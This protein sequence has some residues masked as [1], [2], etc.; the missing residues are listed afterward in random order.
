MCG[1][2]A[3]LFK[4]VVRVVVCESVCV[5]VSLYLCVYVSVYVVVCVSVHTCVGDAQVIHPSALCELKSEAHGAQC[6]HHA[7]DAAALVPFLPQRP[8]LHLVIVRIPAHSGCQ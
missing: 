1:G 8:P 6:V 3:C 7:L 2:R 4:L 5:C